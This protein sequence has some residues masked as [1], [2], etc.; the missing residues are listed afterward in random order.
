MDPSKLAEGGGGSMQHQREEVSSI[1]PDPL[2]T[3]MSSIPSETMTVT[4]TTS[5]TMS[6]G[7]VIQDQNAMENVDGILS[8]YM[9]KLATRL[10]VLET[11]L[12]YAWKALDLLSQEYVV[13]WNRMEKAEALLTQQQGIIARM[14]E[15]QLQ[16]EQGEPPPPPATKG[17]QDP[18]NKKDK[19]D[20]GNGHNGGPNGG[21]GGGGPGG[22]GG[23]GGGPGGG[24]AGRGHDP[25]NMKT[26]DEAF[27]RSL[28]V[29]HRDSGPGA[30]GEQELSL[31]WEE[32]SDLLEKTGGSPSDTNA[33]TDQSKGPTAA[34]TTAVSESEPQ[35]KPT[36]G[37]KSTSKE[38][39]MGG[40][41]SSEEKPSAG[42]T[43]ELTIEAIENHFDELSKELMSEIG[44]KGGS[45]ERIS[46]SVDMD[47]SV[48]SDSQHSDSQH[49]FSALD[50]KDYR[51]SHGS[52]CISDKDIEELSTISS[53]EAK[54][55]MDSIDR[56]RSPSKSSLH[57]HH[58][59]H[60][61]GID[62]ST[63]ASYS[64]TG[65]PLSS[66]TILGGVVG[67]SSA[68][69]RSAM[70]SPQRR[71]KTSRTR[72]KG[73]STLE[74]SL[75]LLYMDSD[76][77]STDLEMSGKAADRL[78]SIS[79]LSHSSSTKLDATT[80]ELLYGC[81]RTSPIPMEVDT[82]SGSMLSTRAV[83]SPS[84]RFSSSSCN[85]YMIT[86]ELM[87]DALRA[88][89][90]SSYR[91]PS[92]LSET[93]GTTDQEV[94]AALIGTNYDPL[95]R[96]S[97]SLS[98]YESAQSST[99]YS[100][101]S[102]ATNGPVAAGSS[103]ATLRTRQ[104]GYL[105][106]RPVSPLPLRY[107]GS[108]SPISKS[109]SPSRSPSKLHADGSSGSP[110]K[111][112]PRN[113]GLYSD[114]PLSGVVDT[115]SLNRIRDPVTGTLIVEEIT[116]SPRLSPVPDYSSRLS[117][118]DLSMTAPS[119]A[120]GLGSSSLMI[121]PNAESSINIR[122]SPRSPK[123]M[124]K[125]VSNG[126]SLMHAK[127]DSGVSELSNWSSHEK[128]PT[129]PSR[130]STTATSQVTSTYIHTQPHLQASLS[131]QQSR[132]L[133]PTLERVQ[134]EG[135]AAGPGLPDVTQRSMDPGMSIPE[136]SFVGHHT[137]EP[138]LPPQQQLAHAA[139][140]QTCGGPDITNAMYAVAHHRHPH[141]DF[142]QQMATSRERERERNL[143]SSSG[144]PGA[145][146]IGLD[147][148][149]RNSANYTICG[150]STNGGGNGV[151][152]RG[153]GDGGSG[154]G[155]S[156][157]YLPASRSSTLENGSRA[158]PQPVPHY[159]HHRTSAEIKSKVAELT[160]GGGSDSD[161][162][163]NYNNKREPYTGVGAPGPG[164]S[165]PYFG[166]GSSS[167]VHR[168]QRDS[169][170]YGSSPYDPRTSQDRHF[171]INSH[172]GLI[173]NTNSSSLT[174]DFHHHHDR[175]QSYYDGGKFT[176]YGPPGGISSYT[177]NKY[178]CYE[179]PSYL[180]TEPGELKWGSQQQMPP[181]YSSRRSQSP[182]L[183]GEGHP[184]HD[185]LTGSLRNMQ[186]ILVS[187]G[188]SATGP[189]K[190]EAG[191]GTYMSAAPYACPPG[192]A[193][194]DMPPHQREYDMSGGAG[195]T[196]P[197]GHDPAVMGMGPGAP[198]VPYDMR[199]FVPGGEINVNQYLHSRAGYLSIG[200][201]GT[202]ESHSDGSQSRGSA[203]SAYAGGAST[204]KQKKPKR[205]ASLKSAMNAV[206]TW[207]HQDLHLSLPRKERSRSLPQSGDDDQPDIQKGHSVP[208]LVTPAPSAVTAS[209][210]STTTRKKKRHSLS[211]VSNISGL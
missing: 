146:A 188:A 58:H 68:H 131:Q 31:I 193:S 157:P 73:R 122:P 69:K 191:A 76:S 14:M 1:R 126:S 192:P 210:P 110:R 205:S 118:N 102:Q 33:P 153:G 61:S 185:N 67:T 78:S 116:R 94:A 34:A 200:G 89:S 88:S 163:T 8:D 97:M 46:S 54:D 103:S 50:Y 144:V 2:L 161:D 62:S 123:P 47:S 120:A 180:V 198:G 136:S 202:P 211:I 20:D 90:P 142:N 6:T 194:Y 60:L 99:P 65:R 170:P 130:Y 71:A 138:G 108:T 44:R 112:S 201:N 81:S 155:L 148:I 19:D 32:D 134:D 64:K 178:A 173:S 174:R 96:I 40:V 181:M 98:R 4:S 160:G 186:N 37:T 16:A 63:L 26:P 119:A 111:V 165:G 49:V 151:D 43:Q 168:N 39:D 21:P 74:E 167:H 13:M 45:K 162:S 204:K 29:A 109:A 79:N 171:L 124:S 139:V 132:A 48:K 127:S 209:A 53:L 22:G 95:G 36:P 28:N 91:P 87:R 57:H 147:S 84:S 93:G 133:S 166:P 17:S 80:A 107:G 42:V 135:A 150:Y 145:A 125:G 85:D 3:T 66:S 152:P 172:Y 140:D 121:D 197:Y 38:G 101:D 56:L 206:G 9:E 169:L 15:E 86:Q 77:G 59:H 158:P 113:S 18:S 114:S 176:V 187:A 179:N 55:I 190:Y 7:S 182:S 83:Q 70:E 196:P 27:Y 177:P 30:V 10:A 203:G 106:G 183:H 24:G 159:A 175:K 104:D 115:I 189:G 72:P 11:E 208:K 184:K 92:R 141:H 149:Q 164:G 35:E 129:S 117:Q 137:P 75:R 154:S 25:R 143:V 23:T 156:S 52:P 41:I 207:M 105:G 12:R 82:S 195:M 51:G 128:S 199:G 100:S 5:G